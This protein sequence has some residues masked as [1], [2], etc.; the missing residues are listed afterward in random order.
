[1]LPRQPLFCCHPSLARWPRL[2]WRCFHCCCSGLRWRS[3]RPRG[4]R[5]NKGNL[6]GIACGRCGGD[7]GCS[8]SNALGA[9][10]GIHRCNTQICFHTQHTP[11]CIEN[12][13]D[14]FL[15]VECRRI[16][17]LSILTL[18][19]LSGSDYLLHQFFYPVVINRIKLCKSPMDWVLYVFKAIWPI[20]T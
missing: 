15:S 6:C 12:R 20:F 3:T 2:W 4:Y 10:F 14:K 9:A 7:H 11:P 18:H 17:A 13:Q 19:K 16:A 1:L 8:H 5:C